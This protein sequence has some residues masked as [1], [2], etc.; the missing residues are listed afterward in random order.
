[1]DSSQDNTAL[2]KLL[3]EALLKAQNTSNV[4]PPK[5]VRIVTKRTKHS[6]RLAERIQK[7]AEIADKLI[8]VIKTLNR[9]SNTEAEVDE[10]IDLVKDLLDNNAKLREQVGETLQDIPPNG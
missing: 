2:R 9:K 7:N 10:L 1:M 4:N 8:D 5:G 6:E 3:A